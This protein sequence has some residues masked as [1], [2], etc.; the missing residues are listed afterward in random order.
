M[1]PSRGMCWWD[2][3]SWMRSAG[4][5]KSERGMRNAEHKDRRRRRERPPIAVPRSAFALP[6]FEVPRSAL[7][8]P[9]RH[10]FGYVDRRRI[11]KLHACE[12]ALEPI[13]RSGPASVTGGAAPGE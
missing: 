2:W 5:T 7:I 6:R 4:G 13:R 1:G 9:R 11:G 3:K 12:A 8:G 10:S